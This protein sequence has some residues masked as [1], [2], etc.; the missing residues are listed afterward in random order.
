MDAALLQAILGSPFW[1]SRDKRC[2]QENDLPRR[3]TPSTGTD[4][5]L[6]LSEALAMARGSGAEEQLT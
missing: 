6:A 5:S 2:V 1:R 4:P 3:K